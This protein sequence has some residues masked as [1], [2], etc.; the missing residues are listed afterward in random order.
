MRYFILSDIHANLEALTA[1]LEDIVLYEKPDSKTK[2]NIFLALTTLEKPLKSKLKKAETGSESK[3]I[4]LGDDIGY[5]AN[6]NECMNITTII[7]DEHLLGNHEV[8]VYSQG[9]K[10]DIKEKY[11]D[12]EKH[13]LTWK[14]TDE[15]LS[16]MNRKYINRLLI[17]GKYAA[18][19][20]G[21]VFSHG[22]P[23][24]K[25]YFYR[26]DPEYYEDLPQVETF[27]RLNRYRNKICFVGHSHQASIV[28]GIIQLDRKVLDGIPIFPRELGNNCNIRLE[29]EKTYL[30]TVSSVGQPRDRCNL[31]GYVIYDSENREVIFRRV[32]Y[33]VQKAAEKIEKI[34]PLMK[35]FAERLYVGR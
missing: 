30:I 23:I 2:E 21:L 34:D 9:L 35:F 19:E 7:A 32:D 28:D 5:G 18:Q 20:N 27:F 12:S 26:C 22:V 15:I 1:C 10:G 29:P 17:E 11:P 13:I 6:P 25:G 4:N 33:D 31:S 8:A 24:E 14:W 3:I 16:K